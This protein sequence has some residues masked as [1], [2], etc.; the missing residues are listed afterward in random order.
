M[1]KGNHVALIRKNDDGT[2]TPMTIPNHRSTTRAIQRFVRG[3]TVDL[4]NQGF[5]FTYNTYPI[6]HTTR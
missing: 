3:A 6:R 5:D 2:E 4:E 1:R